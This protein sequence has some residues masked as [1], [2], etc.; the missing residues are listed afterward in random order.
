MNWFD[1]N[2]NTEAKEIYLLNNHL[3]MTTFDVDLNR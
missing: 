2:L 3:P 1:V